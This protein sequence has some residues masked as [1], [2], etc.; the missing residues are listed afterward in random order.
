MNEGDWLITV[1][2]VVSRRP[3]ALLQFRGLT[4]T[5]VKKPS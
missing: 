1:S 2:S 5:V 3:T 4:Y